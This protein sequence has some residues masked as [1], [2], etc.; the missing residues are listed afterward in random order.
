MFHQPFPLS[1][2]QWNIVDEEMYPSAQ[3][4]DVIHSS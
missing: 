1:K 4:Q 3:E 2:T